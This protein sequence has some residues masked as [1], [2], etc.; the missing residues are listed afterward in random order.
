VSLRTLL[1][2]VDESEGSRAALDFAADLAADLGARVVLLHV[3]EPLAH[4][5]RLAPGVDLRVLRE[6]AKAALAGPLSAELVRRGIAHETRV[7]EGEP[8]RVLVE[9]ADEVGADLL[10]VAARR[11]RRLEELV[12]GS[13][14]ARLPQLTHRPVAIVHA[15]PPGADAGRARN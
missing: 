10:V 14:S 13:T 2:G 11:K 8:A 5:E 4:V 9:V 15:R 3:F 6:R 7:E 1:V 12:L